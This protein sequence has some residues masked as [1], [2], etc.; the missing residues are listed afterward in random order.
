MEFRRRSLL[1]MSL[2]AV[3]TI[4]GCEKQSRI[5]Q[6]PMFGPAKVR[7]HPSFTQ[8]KDWD[9]DGKPDGIEAVVELWD[10]FDEPTRGS[11][12]LLFQLYGYRAA[13]PEPRGERIAEPWPHLLETREQQIAHWSAALRAYTFQLPFPKA[14]RGR[15]YVLDAQFETL[16]GATRPGGGRLFDRLVLEPPPDKKLPEDEID[17][18][19]SRKRQ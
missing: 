7:I 3:T 12:K 4:A 16:G 13:S 10:E 11:G 6:D 1:A 19:G 18:L 17:R 14:Q 8:V 2:L 9:G 5:A 15:T